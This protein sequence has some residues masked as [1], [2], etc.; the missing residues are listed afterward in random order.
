MKRNAQLFNNV[1]AAYG[2]ESIPGEYALYKNKESIKET[3]T[4]NLKKLSDSVTETSDGIITLSA[5]SAKQSDD[6][7]CIKYE[8]QEIIYDEEEDI[9]TNA[10]GSPLNNNKTYKTINISSKEFDIKK[11]AEKNKN[12][13]YNI[14][15]KGTKRYYKI[16]QEQ[17]LQLGNIA[18][19]YD[20]IFIK[21]NA[22]FSSRYDHYISINGAYRLA[23]LIISNIVIL[24]LTLGIFMILTRTVKKDLDKYNTSTVIDDT[25]IDEYGWKQITGDIFRSPK[26]QKI[27]SAFIGTGFEILCVLI[28]SLI[29]SLIGFIKPEIRAKMINYIFICCIV[30]SVISGYMSTFLYRNIGGKE[31]LKNSIVTALFFP[32]ISLIVLGIIRILMTLEQSSAS[33]KL[34]QI[35]LLCFL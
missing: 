16:A 15:E 27:L 12:R 31:W 3:Y 34:S 32:T 33:F 1:T 22:S 8:K 28:V 20:V 24:L 6:Q 23:G 26:H 17:E 35:A 7:I 11:F 18:F 14:L 30:F 5:H 9:L 21:S 4:S 29:L 2:E 19:T 10:D 25:I 13:V